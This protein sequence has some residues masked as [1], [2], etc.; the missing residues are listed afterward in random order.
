MS[1]TRDRETRVL[2]SVSISPRA[3]Q[4]LDEWGEQLGGAI[5][6]SALINLAILRLANEPVPTAASQNNTCSAVAGL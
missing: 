6:R 1:A 2:T 3:K 5:S 4:I